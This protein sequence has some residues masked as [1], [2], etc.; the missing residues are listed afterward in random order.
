MTPAGPWKTF[1]ALAGLLLPAWGFSQVVINEVCYDPDGADEGREWIEL[2]NAGDTDINLAG[3]RLFSGGSQFGE[4]FV[5]PHYILRAQRFVVVGGEQVSQAVFTAP[6]AF[7]NG[8]SATDG[9]RYLS[10]DGSYTDTVL[11]D[12]PNANGLPDD[13]GNPGSSFAPDASEGQSLARR[14]DGYDTNDCAADLCAEPEPTPGVANRVYVDYALLHPQAWQEDEAWQFGIWVKNLSGI[15]PQLGADLFIYLDGLQIAQH[16]VGGP[17]SGDSTRVL[18]ALPVT[19]TQNHQILACLELENDPDPA[20]NTVTLDLFLQN[21]LP[22]VINEL[23]FHPETGKQ[24]W[25]ELWVEAEPARADFRIRDA[26]GNEFSFT[27]PAQA[28]YFVLCSEPELFMLQYPGC[29]SSAVIGTSGWAALNNDGDSVMLLDTE[30]NSLDQM[31]YTGAGSQAGK[32]LERHLD[33]GQQT[34]WR[35]SLDPS[36]STPGQANSQTAQVPDFTGCISVVG[37]PCNPHNGG[38]LSIFYQLD[39]PQSHANCRLYDLSGCLVRILADS[40]LIPGEGA[41]TWDGKNTAGRVVPRGRYF[42]VWESR[43]TDGQK[44]YRE[45]FTAVV[46]Y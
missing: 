45:Q 10:P 30:E 13:T 8:G 39:S 22:P 1:L 33:S 18:Q 4:V 5:F 43:P 7:Q 20:N 46:F 12:F 9:V 29:P 34:L 24:E 37:S 23:M 35:Y 44:I 3:A 17:A 32:S 38:Q 28:G 14:M 15:S 27:L 21:L 42:F 2:Y 31:N 19:D 40:S 36:G 26:S 41:L 16:N 25:V 11:Y 6:L